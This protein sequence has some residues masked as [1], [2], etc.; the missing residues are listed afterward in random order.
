MADKKDRDEL[1]KMAGEIF[2]LIKLASAAR[3]RSRAGAPEV[4]SETEF[5]TLDV[6]TQQEPITVGEVQKRI[7]VVPAQ[8]S[9]IIRS[10]ENKSGEVLVTCSINPDDRRKVDVR[11]TPKGRQAHEAYR[12][13]RLGFATEILRSLE[14]ED[15]RRFMGYLNQIREGLTKRLKTQ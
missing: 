10:L 8:M 5:L 1:N 7:G 11:V 14:H 12:S 13:V 3:A 9:R 6:L 4:L 2:E 15:R